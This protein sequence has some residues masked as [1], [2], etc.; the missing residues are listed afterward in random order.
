MI[1]ICFKCNKAKEIEL[2]YKHPKTKDGFVNSCI[3]C[4]LKLNTDNYYRKKLLQEGFAEKE[5][6]RSKEKYYRLNYKE[7]LIERNKNKH[8][9][10]FNLRR[11]LK[12]TSKETEC[13]HWNYNYNYI[14]DVFLL[15]RLEHRKCHT[16][17]KLIKDKL[18]FM[19]NNGEL[20]DTKDKH[21]EY[22]INKGI[23]F[24]Q[25]IIIND[26]TGKL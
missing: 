18:I 12:I 15:N 1:K 24:E 22:L 16:F 3:E 21:K 8:S 7:K 10:Y 11:K 23:I 6:L 26:N 25:Q 17:L 5:R 13:H 19:G 9:K 14:E 4:S 2:F 20:L